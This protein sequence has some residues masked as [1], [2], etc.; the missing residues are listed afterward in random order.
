MEGVWGGGGRSEGGSRVR[1][2]GSGSEAA[3]GGVGPRQWRLWT[4]CWKILEIC[5]GP[6]SL[7]FFVFF[8]LLVARVISSASPSCGTR[9][10]MQGALW[11]GQK[12][13]WDAVMTQ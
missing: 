13:S 11:S 9:V 10:G 1:A 4:L 3:W 12:R 5:R 2:V 6:I 8:V 7:H